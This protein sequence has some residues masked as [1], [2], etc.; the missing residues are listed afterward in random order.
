VDVW[1]RHYIRVLRNVY[2]CI[3]RYIFSALAFLSCCGLAFVWT[4]LIVVRVGR[5]S[6]ASLAND[7]SKLSQLKSI[8]DLV[9]EQQ[10]SRVLNALIQENGRSH[11]QTE[12]KTSQ[13]LNAGAW[14]LGLRLPSNWFV[15]PT[16]CLS[17]TRTRSRQSLVL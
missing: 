3:D 13:I 16:S 12:A 2:W 9:T 14:F 17:S 6:D 7:P 8:L 15:M 5:S 10:A 11:A 1:L 4:L